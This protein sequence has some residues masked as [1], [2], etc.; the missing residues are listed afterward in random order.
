MKKLTNPQ[1]LIIELLL[2]TLSVLDWLVE[3]GYVKKWRFPCVLA[4]ITVKSFA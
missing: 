4:N 2:L 1:V 3:L